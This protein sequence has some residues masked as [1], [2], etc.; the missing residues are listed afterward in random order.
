M[1]FG[2]NYAEKDEYR[3]PIVP[4]N[5]TPYAI[6]TMDIE[7]VV[8]ESFYPI[9]ISGKWGIKWRW[10]KSLDLWHGSVIYCIKNRRKRIKNFFAIKPLLFN[11]PFYIAI[12]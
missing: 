12:R 7:C 10:D 2:I 1:L 4:F 9:K 11:I 3:I 6:C 8:F 5:F